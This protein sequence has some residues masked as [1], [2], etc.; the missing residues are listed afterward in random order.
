M[1][2]WD[3]A[4]ERDRLIGVVQ[5]SMLGLGANRY[6]LDDRRNQDCQQEQDYKFI[7]LNFDDQDYLFACETGRV[8]LALPYLDE[9]SRWRYKD[10]SST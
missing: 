2:G 9:S 1:R 6:G 5:P 8:S 4:P 7:Q 10:L 3:A